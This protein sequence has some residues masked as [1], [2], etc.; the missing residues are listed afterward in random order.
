M[1]WNKSKTEFID[2]LKLDIDRNLIPQIEREVECDIVKAITLGVI[3]LRESDIYMKDLLDYK[4]DSYPINEGYYH[5]GNSVEENIEEI[6]EVLETEYIREYVKY[7]IFMCNYLDYISSNVSYSLAE[8]GITF[9]F[10]SS[11]DL[12]IEDLMNEEELDYNQ[13]HIFRKNILIDDI[14]DKY[15]SKI[16]NYRMAITEY[17]LFKDIEYPVITDYISEFIFKD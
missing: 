6:V 9:I 12:F 5:S 11:L 2:N 15:R 14:I 3:K 7:C 10:N 16:I 13:F 17:Y 4:I 1:N 8:D